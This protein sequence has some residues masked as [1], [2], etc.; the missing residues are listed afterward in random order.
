[1]NSIF[2]E[3]IVGPFSTV[4]KYA[5]SRVNGFIVNPADT[6]TSPGWG[7]PIYPNDD[8]S[9][10][11][12][13]PGTYGADWQYT[14]LR[15]VGG[16]WKEYK[17]KKLQS[18]GPV[19]WYGTEIKDAASRKDRYILS[20]WGPRSRHFADGFTYSQDKRYTYIYMNGG[21][22][23][24]APG[25]VL[26]AALLAMDSTELADYKPKNIKFWLV[27]VVLEE[28][29]EVVYRRALLPPLFEYYLGDSGAKSLSL[30]VKD[31]KYEPHP[32]G[33]SK[34]GTC[35]T[36]GYNTPKTPWFFSEDGKKASAIRTKDVTH[37]P[38]TGVTPPSTVEITEAVGRVCRISITSSS[39]SGTQGDPE[40]PYVM[41]VTGSKTVLPNYITPVDK[42][43][44]THEF[45]EVT[46]KTKEVTTGTQIVAVDYVGDE[47]VIV[48]LVLD[49][50]HEIRNDIMK[51]VD[52]YSATYPT[53]HPAAGQPH[54]RNTG[55]YYNDLPKNSEDDYV[56]LGVLKPMQPGGHREATWYISA[57]YNS[58]QFTVAGK[59]YYS[60]TEGLRED[61]NSPD[62]NAL[63][64]GRYD[65]LSVRYL[66]V[67]HRILFGFLERDDWRI[68]GYPSKVYYKK[69]E[70]LIDDMATER[71]S[72]F[73]S[74]TSNNDDEKATVTDGLLYPYRLRQ[75]ADYVAMLELEGPNPGGTSTSFSWS[76]TYT[77]YAGTRAT[78]NDDESIQQPSIVKLLFPS[79]PISMK[80][81][82]GMACLDHNLFTDECGVAI[83][84]NGTLIANF[85]VPDQDA[86][87]GSYKLF[88]I[89][90]DEVDPVKLA[91]GEKLY[92]LGTM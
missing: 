48:R 50:H 40:P 43:G 68:S 45:E 77:S 72:T 28:G 91:G 8:S 83:L 32:V 66:D 70:V 21:I 56:Y 6:S 58:L 87:D 1:M 5:G 19:N 30:L 36:E 80:G 38:L 71:L 90:S 16:V 67:R 12:I 23:G 51:G 31:E 88:T 3:N 76:F 29:Q 44:D 4:S 86:H 2:T 75:A 69:Q 22:V 52:S 47:E 15:M 82:Q 39:A 53:G 46:Y 92:P 24:S 78:V 7:F 9:Q 17:S 74:F 84:P 37:I 62:D 55:K 35:S 41:E 63:V 13:F 42:W 27:A 18:V 81:C 10:A 11:R 73:R 61:A 89:H 79:L 65:R 20:Y 64:R 59:K 85:N 34:L 49:Y 54:I 33:W 26:G 60:T 57:A 25:P 14:A